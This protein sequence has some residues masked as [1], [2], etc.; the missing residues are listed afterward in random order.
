MDKLSN[1][2]A[3]ASVPLNENDNP[4]PAWNLQKQEK[5]QDEEEDGVA[6]KMVESYFF[7]PE[8]RQGNIR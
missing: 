6:A 7:V 4:T 5:Q 1:P 2:V 3:F 8:P